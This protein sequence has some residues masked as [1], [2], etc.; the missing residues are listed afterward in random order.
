MPVHG[1]ARTQ[2]MPTTKLG[3]DR[4]G[5]DCTGRR[6]S[7]KTAT[8]TQAYER[9]DFHPMESHRTYQL[10]SYDVQA[11]PGAYGA[12]SARGAILRFLEDRPMCCVSKIAVP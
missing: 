9:G 1:P 6:V 11:R 3:T 4:D 10:T 5:P 2:R 7:A 12:D 8:W